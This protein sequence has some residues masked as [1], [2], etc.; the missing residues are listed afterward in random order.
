MIYLTAL[1]DAWG[2]IFHIFHIGG[3]ISKSRSSSWSI[4]SDHVVMTSKRIQPGMEEWL[5]KRP[6]RWHGHTIHCLPHLLLLHPCIVGPY[7]F[8]LTHWGRYKMVAILQT[9][10]WDIFKISLKFVPRGP[11]N[12]ITT[13]VQIMTWHRPGDKPLSE[14]MMVSLYESHRLNE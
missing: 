8:A 13:L 4:L 7:Q 1:Q 12:N 10:F 9:T 6:M 11:I 3:S 5:M 14:P 2:S